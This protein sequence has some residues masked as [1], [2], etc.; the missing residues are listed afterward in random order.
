MLLMTMNG[1]WNMNARVCQCSVCCCHTR[2]AKPRQ[3]ELRQPHAQAF[4]IRLQTGLSP[5]K[6]PPRESVNRMHMTKFWQMVDRSIIFGPPSAQGLFPCPAKFDK[7][8][9]NRDGSTCGDHLANLNLTNLRIVL[10]FRTLPLCSALLM[11][12]TN[13]GETQGLGCSLLVSGLPSSFDKRFIIDDFPPPPAWT[14]FPTLSLP[15]S[16][17]SPSFPLLPPTAISHKSL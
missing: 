3:A 17:S 10:L 14:C 6:N 4:D 2:Q 16:L 13:V 7:H 15:S 12:R 5:A 9:K 1:L 11:A 8:S